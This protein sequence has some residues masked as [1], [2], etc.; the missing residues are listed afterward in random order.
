[1]R[2][3]EAHAQREEVL[4][5]QRAVARAFSSPGSSAAPAAA[6]ASVAFG[7]IRASSGTRSPR[8]WMQ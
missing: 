1:V 6:S 8:S 4:S 2:A 7:V 3:I 5:P